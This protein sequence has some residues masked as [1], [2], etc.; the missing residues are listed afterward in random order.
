MPL[1]W[2]A[3][4]YASGS[5]WA[6]NVMREIVAV[7]HPDRPVIGRF[8]NTL[9]DLAGIDDDASQVVKSHDLA[10]DVAVALS[11]RADHLVVTIRDPRDAVTSLMLYQRYPFAMAL[12]TIAKSA[13]FVGGFAADKRTLLLRY[14]DGYPDDPTT[15]ARLARS[16]GAELPATQAQAIFANS[17]RAAIEQTI[18]DLATLPGAQHDPRSGDI[19][20]PQTQWHKHHAGRTGEVGRWRRLLLPGQITAVEQKL[21][22]WMARFGYH[23]APLA[24]IGYSLNI[25]SF[26]ITPSRNR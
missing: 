10:E 7:L 11:G 17:R 18:K 16:F 24:G 8:V 25:G 23:R 20:D 21:A 22:D 4:M 14:E 3:G 5:T 9:A 19:F 26:T 1:Y 2:C 6:Y 12:D 15:P 13:E